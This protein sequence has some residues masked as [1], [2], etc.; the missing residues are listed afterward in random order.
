MENFSPQIGEGRYVELKD[1]SLLLRQ[2]DRERLNDRVAW[3]GQAERSRILEEAWFKGPEVYDQIDDATAASAEISIETDDGSGNCEVV[4]EDTVYFET[5]EKRIGAVLEAVRFS[6]ARNRIG[7]L[8]NECI[9]ETLAI[10]DELRGVVRRHARAFIIAAG[11]AAGA[12]ATWAAL[13][14]DPIP[15]A[16]AAT[17]ST[18]E[19][20]AQSSL[21]DKR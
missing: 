7:K 4:Y 11:F 18:E 2:R 10:V 12:S 15:V 6:G 16:H 14:S 20:I 19:D 17:H 9:G 13:N 3:M 5:L 21:F 1:G 8:V